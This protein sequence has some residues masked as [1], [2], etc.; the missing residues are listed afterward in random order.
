M[1]Y[2]VDNSLERIGTKSRYCCGLSKVYAFCRITVYSS[3]CDLCSDLFEFVL[4]E[5]GL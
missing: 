2:T 1:Y 4:T 5:V 3:V